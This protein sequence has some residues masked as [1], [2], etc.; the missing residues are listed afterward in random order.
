MNDTQLRNLKPSEKSYRVSDGCGLYVQ[1]EPSGGKLWRLAYRY[2]GKQKTLALGR[3]PEVGLADARAR[4]D[5]AK[6]QLSNGVD[7][8]EARKLEK[9]Q[10]VIAANTTFGAIAKEWFDNRKSRWVESYSS[11]IWSRIE[12]DL[13]ILQNRPIGSITPLEVL[14]ALREV[15][16]RGAYNAAEWLDGRRRMMNAWADYVCGLGSLSPSA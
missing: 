7:P 16:A 12:S 11:R 9:R 15:E 1:I 4:R 2:H 3:Y 6:R 14:D 10:S 13:F 8:G 5:A